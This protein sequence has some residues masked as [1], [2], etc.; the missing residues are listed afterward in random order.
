MY[1]WFIVHSKV[2]RDTNYTFREV[3]LSSW[4]S[5]EAAYTWYK[6][7]TAHKKIVKAYNNG[8]MLGFST[9]IGTLVS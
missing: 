1:V 7:S 5:E 6:N 3:N 9:M 8:D 2:R 4:A